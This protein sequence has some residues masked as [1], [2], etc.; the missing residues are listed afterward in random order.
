MVV[1]MTATAIICNAM[2]LQNSHRPAPLFAPRPSANAVPLPTPAPDFRPAATP[3]PAPQP[4]LQ[5]VQ[6]VASPQVM[7]PPLPRPAPTAKSAPVATTAAAKPAPLPPAPVPATATQSPS[8]AQQQTALVIEIQRGLA[9]LGIYTGAIDGKSGGRTSAAIAKYETAA[10]LKPTGQATPELLYAL[11]HPTAAPAVAAPP[12]ADPIAAQLDSSAERR[13]AS[14]AADNAAADAK[15]ATAAK[16]QAQAQA[17]QAKAAA[18]T[19]AAGTYRTVQTALNRIGYGPVPVDGTANTPTVDAIR[20]FELDNGLPVSGEPSDALTA[21]LVA[22]G[23]I[24][25]N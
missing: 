20:R 23:A 19:R 18:Q 3:A 11:Q 9:R 17:A 4:Q 24:K 21:R 13:A 22:I 7:T 25:S 15:A 2:F 10:G 14:I 16:A 1:A 6:R 8:E 12:A 5:P